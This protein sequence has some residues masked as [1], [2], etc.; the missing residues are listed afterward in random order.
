MA[1]GDWRAAIREA[2]AGVAEAQIQLLMP[3]ALAVEST[4]QP[5]E[6]AEGALKRLMECLKAGGGA[7]SRA[8]LERL[9]REIRR[10]RALL[11]GAAALRLG[12]ARRLLVAACGYTA[13]GDVALPQLARRLSVEG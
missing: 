12:W 13:Q 9:G 4:W 1:N 7:E 8:E 10:L 5:L 6:R 2:Q 11:E 3:T